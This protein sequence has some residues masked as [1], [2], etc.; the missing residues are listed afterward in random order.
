[1][2]NHLNSRKN[3]PKPDRELEN[4]YNNSLTFP[5]H[6]PSNMDTVGKLWNRRIQKYSLLDVKCPKF[7]ENLVKTLGENGEI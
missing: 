6:K 2:S 4:N 7:M 5:V 3:R 1:M